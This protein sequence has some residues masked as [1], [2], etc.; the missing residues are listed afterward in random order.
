MHFRYGFVQSLLDNILKMQKSCVFEHGKRTGRNIKNKLNAIKNGN[1]N[2]GI[3]YR[4][5][6]NHLVS[7][8]NYNDNI[9]NI[10]SNISNLK[11]NLTKALMH[12]K[13]KNWANGFKIGMS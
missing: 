11:R 3:L 6:I 12:N 5:L 13:S 8:N 2:N 10:Y 9:E 4:E 1:N 7:N